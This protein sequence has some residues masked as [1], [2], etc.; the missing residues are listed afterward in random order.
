V[1]RAVENKNKNH[2]GAAKADGDG[3]IVVFVDPPAR[4]PSP[5]VRLIEDWSD[6]EGLIL[7][8]VRRVDSRAEIDAECRLAVINVGSRSVA[9]RAVL[10]TME[11]LRTRFPGAPVVV[12]SELNE[13]SEVFAAFQAGVQ[14]FIP[15]SLDPKVALQALTFILVGGSYF[16]SSALVSSIGKDRDE[17]PEKAGKPR[18]GGTPAESGAEFLDILTPRQRQVAVLL[19]DGLTNKVIARKL[20]LSEATV[21]VHIRQIMGKLQIS[22][23]TQLALAIHRALSR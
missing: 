12:L 20:G 19:K 14:G 6:T 15:A 1:R 10:R 8:S 23:R 9:S 16:P 3:R 17:E 22:N 21:K 13:Q 11:T 7:K 5:A 18:P 4:E 2:D